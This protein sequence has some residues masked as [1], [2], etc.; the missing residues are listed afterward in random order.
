LKNETLHIEKIIKFTILEQATDTD[1]PSA[2]VALKITPSSGVGGRLV[3][4]IYDFNPKVFSYNEFD[5]SACF[6][7]KDKIEFGMAFNY[8]NGIDEQTFRSLFMNI[9]AE[10]FYEPVFNV[11]AIYNISPLRIIPAQVQTHKNGFVIYSGLTNA[12]AAISI[13]NGSIYSIRK[14]KKKSIILN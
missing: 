7:P 14:K 5:L 3:I 12:T 11:L 4:N 8:D 13:E 1:Y 2:P 9:V 6:P 10:L